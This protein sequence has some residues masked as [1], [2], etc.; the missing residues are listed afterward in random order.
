MKKI[1]ITLLA[2]ILVTNI[3]GLTSAVADDDISYFFKHGEAF[4][5]TRECFYNGAYCNQSSFTCYITIIAPNQTIILNNSLMTGAINYYSKVIPDTNWPNGVYRNTMTCSDGINSGSEVFYFKINQS[6]DSR[7]NALFLILSL[8]SVIVLGFGILF[9]NEYIGFVA[10]ALFITTGVY[11]M[12]FGF[13]DLADIY[14]RSIAYVC[15]GLGLIFEVAAGYKVAE[16]T[17]ITSGG[18]FSGDNWE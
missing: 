6:G 4:N 18:V 2:L 14:T 7:T 12:I 3:I 17:G 9:Q 11:V 13:A 15:I 8:G 16:E 1:L 5:I 10:G